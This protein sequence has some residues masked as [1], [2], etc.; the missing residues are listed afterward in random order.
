MPEHSI[1]QDV[2]IIFSV[3]IGVVF[4][5][6]KLRLPSIAGFLVAGTLVGPY[7]LNLIS[8]REQITVLAEIGVILLLFTIGI[9]FSL[10]QLKASRRVLFISG[11][12]QIMG[13]L[14]CVA[15][16]GIALGLS[17]QET[18]FW[19]SLLS[20]SSTAIVLKALGERGEMDTHHGRSTIGILLFQDLAV[21][22][23]ILITPLL[24]NDQTGDMS[25]IVFILLKSALVVT[26]IVVAARVITPNLLEHIVRTRSRELFLLTIIV[27][28]L[29]TAWLTSLTGLS[30]ALGA[31]LAGLLIS[32]SQYS[33]QALA[34][35][36]PFRDSFNSLF[37]VSI[38]MLIDL[39]VIA[40][41]PALI[42]GLVLAVLLGK[43]LTAAGAAFAAG[44]PV[45][46]GILTGVA[47]AQVGEFAFILAQEGR[48]AHLLEA[49][50]Y[51]IFLS[52]CVLSMIITPFLIQWAP[53]LA[54]RAEAL[55]RVHHW[56]GRREL[57]VLASAPLK[58]KDH[59]IIVGYGL[60]GR[61]LARVLQDMEIPYLVLDIGADLVHAAKNLGVHI[62]YGDATNPTV[63]K[64]VQIEQARAI[65]I[66]T[67]DPFGVRR[68]VQLAREL[69]AHIHIVVRTRYLKEL[70]ELHD[71]GANEVIPE[72]FETSIEIF[73]LVLQCYKIPKP[74]IFEKAEEIRREGYALLRREELPALAHRFR[75]GGFADVE[76]ETWRVEEDSPA[77]GHSLLQTAIQRKTGTVVVALTRNG[78]TQSKPSNETIL[79]AGDILVLLG[80]REQI[81]KAIALISD[82]QTILP[83]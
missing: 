29:G 50:T 17:I 83:T 67:S 18:I 20:L 82:I 77:L 59:V 30:L 12:A 2:L 22:P 31:F 58:I 79:E 78:I 80:S 60:N 13:V 65:V 3:S 42:L 14:L 23:M 6:Q 25:A 5:F 81:H 44:A 19:G 54:K 24:G 48:Q 64:Q 38:G 45:R 28:G 4:L 40:S 11:P 72:E 9:E 66:A 55:H 1:L 52:V 56:F 8:D 53:K 76:V 41:H 32:E 7:G 15:I 71:L 49:Q 36:L 46:S 16:G 75:K 26:L 62:Q 21:V 34:E 10:A 43:F 39:R 47:L 33:H 27:L 61:N 57:G 35:V 73:T 70:E 51:N 68:T 74:M 37:F 63:L 69:N